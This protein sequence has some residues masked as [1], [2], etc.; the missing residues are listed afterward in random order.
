V[1]G[2]GFGDQH[3]AVAFAM[4]AGKNEASSSRIWS[5]L[6]HAGRVSLF[7]AFSL[8]PSSA[9]SSPSGAMRRKSGWLPAASQR[10]A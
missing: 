10:H 1:H 6:D 2:F 5:M 4:A 9:S 7:G 3:H 8:A